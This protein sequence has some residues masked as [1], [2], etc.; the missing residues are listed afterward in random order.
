MR[1]LDL[2]RPASE[3][4]ESRRSSRFP[5]I[6]EE[7]EA[8]HLLSAGPPIVPEPAS[9]PVAIGASRQPG[10]A[11]GMFESLGSGVSVQTTGTGGVQFLQSALPVTGLLDNLSIGSANVVTSAGPLTVSSGLLSLPITPLIPPLLSATETPLNNGTLLTGTVW[12]TPPPL[13]TNHFQLSTMIAPPVSNSM[14]QVPT[15]Q[16]VPLVVNQFGQGSAN[17]SP[18]SLDQ[19]VSPVGPEPPKTI[20]QVEPTQ[21]P[22]TEQPPTGQPAQ[23]QSGAQTPPAGAAGQQPNGPTAQEIGGAAGQSIGG[24]AGQKP[25]GQSSPQNPASSQQGQGPASSPGSRKPTDS[26]GGSTSGPG[27]FRTPSAPELGP[28]PIAAD[29][30][31]IDVALDDLDSSQLHRPSDDRDSALPTLLGAALVVGG[32]YRIALRRSDRL[33]SDW[34]PEP[35]ESKRT[36]ARGFGSPSRN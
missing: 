5:L 12:I 30:E 13:T 15:F 29:M 11:A 31:L 9:E 20:D 14:V 23:T 27:V 8:H 32:G 19:P 36:P 24:A 33:E 2:I 10:N 3:R 34:V 4:M 21:P 1:S 25:Y 16:E 35:A 17:P 26:S 22:A 6:H 28:L 7:L 18:S